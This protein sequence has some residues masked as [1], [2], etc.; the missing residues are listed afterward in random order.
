MKIKISMLLALCLGSI[1]FGAGTLTPPGAPAPTMKTLQ[2]VEPRTP[3]EAGSQGVSINTNGTISIIQSG[4]YYLTSNLTVATGNGIIVLTN[5]V[6]VDLNGFTIRS[7][8]PAVSGSGIRIE[9]SSVSVVNGHIVSGTVFDSTV[10]GDQYTGS[11]FEN[12]VYAPDLAQG[13]GRNIYIKNV[14]VSGCDHGGIFIVSGEYSMVESCVVKV[15]GGVGIQAGVITKCSVYSSGSYAIRGT[16]ISD[17]RGYS[18]GETAVYSTASV[19]NSFGVSY[20]ESGSKYG[21]Y[22]G[23]SVQN[24]FGYSAS[25]TGIYS[26]GTV[27]NCSGDTTSATTTATGIFSG[28]SVHASYG[29][30]MHGIGIQTQIAGY[31]YGY[32]DGSDSSAKGIQAEIAVACIA[33]GGENITHK[34]LMP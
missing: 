3:L 30:S 26:G 20:A 32:T 34:Y 25:S 8:S 10:S 4:S 15:V 9:G 7:L 27:I 22:A 5:G 17:C 13:L 1:A 2:Q 11:G 33:V 29:F 14:T 23:V 31:S 16:V 24:S 12:G 6:T 18:E 21:I 28:A 19:L